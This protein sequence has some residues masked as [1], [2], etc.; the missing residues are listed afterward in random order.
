M[1]AAGEESRAWPPS[2]SAQRMATAHVPLPAAVDPADRA[3]VAA[4]VEALDRGDELERVVAGM[5]AEGRRRRERLHHL[6][7]VRRRRRQP[8]LDQGAQVLHV[9]HRDD[10]GLRL[11]VEVAAPRQERLV[12][13]VDDDPVLDL[14]LGRGDER[15]REAGVRGRVARPG[16]RAG[17]RVRAHDV[18]VAGDQQLRARRRRS[19]PS[20]TGSC[21][22]NDARSRSRMACTSSGRSAVTSTS[23]AIT[24]LVSR[25]ARTSSRPAATA[26]RYVSTGTPGRRVNAR[27]ARRRAGLEVGVRRRASAPSI[28]VIHRVP[29]ASLPTI[30]AGMT[31]S[32]PS[33][34]PE[35]QHPER[36]GTAARVARPRRRARSPASTSG[37]AAS[38]DARRHASAGQADAVAHEQE[39]VAA[40]EAVEVDVAVE[41]S[42]DGPQPAHVPRRRDE[43]R[44]ATRQQAPLDAS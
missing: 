29:S 39:A 3:A 19:R 26:A 34:R 9:G 2:I 12:H 1:P 6:E 31:S 44:D 8:A 21:E 42:G 7:H 35:G 43:L 40:G 27:A 23:R 38:R 17:E 36:H 14:V 10:R 41:R 16:R 33:R 13:H 4:A 32:V 37:T 11:P 22:P 5:A 15:G 30:T 20:S 25:P 28:V 24:T 18:A